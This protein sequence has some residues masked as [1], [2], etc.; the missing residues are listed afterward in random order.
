M[1]IQEEIDDA[2]I[3]EVRLIVPFD[4]FILLLSYKSDN[5]QVTWMTT[6]PASLK[7]DANVTKMNQFPMPTLLFLVISKPLMD[8]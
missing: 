4:I 7:L 1:I 5:G 3:R 8:L 6:I 2:M